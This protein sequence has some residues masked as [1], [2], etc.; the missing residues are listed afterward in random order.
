MFA[1]SKHDH[2][3]IY[4]GQKLLPARTPQSTLA[5]GCFFVV[6]IHISIVLALLCHGEEQAALREKGFVHLSHSQQ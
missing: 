1:V 6:C 5:G 3:E 2:S 4:A